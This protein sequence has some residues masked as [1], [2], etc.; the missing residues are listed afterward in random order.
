MFSYVRK[1]GKGERTKKEA[2]RYFIARYI[3]TNPANWNDDEYPRHQPIT[4]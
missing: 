3:L 4:G 2:A 1:K